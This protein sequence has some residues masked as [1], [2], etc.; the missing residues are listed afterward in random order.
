MPLRR[1]STNREKVV[2]FQNRQL[3]R[4]IRHAYH[5]VP[6]YRSL[7]DRNGIHPGDIR[8]LEDLETIPLTA[9]A[10]LRNRSLKDIFSR[11]TRP[12][13][14]VKRKTSG[15]SGMP[16][17][18]FRAPLEDHLINLF[19]IQA[20]REYGMRVQDRSVVI[21]EI[22]AAGNARRILS[23]CKE[24]FGIYRTCLID[25]YS[26]EDQIVAE[27]E[28][29]RPDIVIGYPSVLA[30]LG[31]RLCRE[32]R[33]RIR[34]RLV[35]TG[36]GVLTADMRRRIEEGF[37]CPLFDVYGAHEFNILAYE[38]PQHGGAYHVCDTNVIL[39]ILKDGRP[40]ARGET[41]EVVATGL[42]TLAMPFIRY[43]TGDV[44]TRGDAACACGHPF[45]TI[46]H[47][48]GRTIDYFQL[49]E[50]RLVHPYT[51][52]APLV[53]EENAWICQHQLVQEA[54]NH[55]VLRIQPF[56]PPRSQDIERLRRL[57]QERVGP[58]ARFSVELVKSFVHEPGK[59]FP[60]YVRRIEKNDSSG[61]ERM[62]K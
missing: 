37:V 22:P 61:M 23:R 9:K 21:A 48:Q 16:F 6:H 24:A 36:G 59:K 53:K 17:A 11:S 47:I 54:E 33:E 50:T 2:D 15:S 25:C 18:I 58:G 29:I 20:Y 30:L 38:C 32:G 14:L 35:V 7:F 39:E 13:R 52:T 1:A 44:A 34:P 5:C 41:G 31:A 45:Q 10:D 55:V 28:R 40:A 43:R 56:H 19:R 51:I 49:A 26:E 8:G 42:H 4:L 46:S 62:H 57:G 12:E 3:H 60:P 27:L